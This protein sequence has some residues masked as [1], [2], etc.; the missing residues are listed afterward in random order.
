MNA[1]RMSPYL[2]RP[3]VLLTA[4]CIGSLS[5]GEAARAEN[6]AH[7]ISAP[8]TIRLAAAAK[9][10][11][12]APADFFSQGWRLNPRLSHIYMQ[13]VKKNLIFETH[14]FTVME[15]RID[16]DGKAS[17]MI[18]LASLQTGIDV[19]DVRMRF[20]FFETFKFPTAE[21]TATLDKAALQDLLIKNRLETTL[22]FT[23]NLHG[24]K[25]DIEAPV[26]V[27]RI[28]DNAVSVATAKP[29]IIRA[30]D[31]ELAAGIARLAEAA[32]GF[33]I[34]PAASISFD[35][36]FEGTNFN[37]QLEAAR[38]AAA[39]LRAEENARDMTPTAC[40]TRLDVISK[41]RA[42][43]FRIASAALDKESEH[44]LNTLAGIAKRCPTV[45][46]EVSGHT[47]SDG[48][49]T[50][51]QTLSEKRAR[52]VSDYLIAR[53]IATRRLQTRGYGDAR[54]V[55]P[56]NTLANKARNRRIEFRVI[57]GTAAQ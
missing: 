46:M 28:I 27:T 49:K 4:L 44:I 12:A 15:G 57:A 33:P 20:L 52:A 31:F 24:V 23:L 14:K 35:L 2:K 18:E 9:P 11:A 13:S 21:V 25:K 34:A 56:N 29:I 16:E 45:K 43:Y 48:R 37:P 19:R 55:A 3:V 1:T 41:T 26:V 10:P 17:I 6:S 47:D 32:G 39:K 30:A 5:G 51:N 7:G 36:I 42:I 22:R 40:K 38:V 54:P 8:E 50:A 53:G